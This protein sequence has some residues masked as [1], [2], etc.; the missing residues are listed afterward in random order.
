MSQNLLIKFCDIWQNFH[1]Y[2]ILNNEYFKMEVKQMNTIFSILSKNS[3]VKVS[4]GND[5]L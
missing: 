4:N 5:E 2:Y 3:S 1:F